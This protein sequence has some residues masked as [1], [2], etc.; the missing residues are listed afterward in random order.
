M[1]L[2]LSPVPLTPA[3]TRAPSF[4]IN[5]FLLLV[6][7]FMSCLCVTVDYVHAN[8]AD[9]LDDITKHSGSRQLCFCLDVLRLSSPPECEWCRNRPL[10]RVL[11]LHNLHVHEHHAIGPLGYW[12][13]LLFAPACRCRGCPV[14]HHYVRVATN[15]G[16]LEGG[17]QHGR[18]NL[19]HVCFALVLFVPRFL[20][21]G[22]K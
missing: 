13:I 5:V 17:H 4:F 18:G 14:P 16:E 12:P 9:G 7:F 21:F 11:S 1:N 19:P 2:L 8:P 10:F 15:R 6:L 3:C 20:G 22:R